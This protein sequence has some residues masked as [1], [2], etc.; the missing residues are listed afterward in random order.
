M[1]KTL[2]WTRVVFPDP[3]IPRTTTQ[4]G[5]FSSGTFVFKLL[6]SIGTST[7]EEVAMA[8]KIECFK[9]KNRNKNV[10]QIMGAA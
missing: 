4:M 8:N 6:S 1:I 5:T 10:L 9:I 7:F 3:A 2:T